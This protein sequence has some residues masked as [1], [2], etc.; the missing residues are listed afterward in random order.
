MEYFDSH[1]HCDSVDEF[2]ELMGRAHDAGVTRMLAVG[3]SPEADAVIMSIVRRFPEI[4]SGAIGF[5]RDEAGM[6]SSKEDGIAIAV[7]DLKSRIAGFVVE[8]LN[9]LAIGEVGLDFH[10]ERETSDAQVDLLRA[11][12]SLAGELGLPV[13]L[14]SREADDEMLKLLRTHAEGYG[15]RQMLGVLHCFTGGRKFAEALLDLGY[16][17]SFSGIVTFRNADALR[18]VV[19]IVPDECLL[20]ETDSPYLAP[21]PHRGKKNEPAYLP[22][23]AKV[24]ADLRGV[25]EQKIAALTA[26]NAERL[27]KVLPNIEL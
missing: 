14:H 8:G 16:Y 7:A 2:I 1:M 10:Y 3:G 11:Q 26:E 20:I 4:V 15:D 18:E 23:V 21:V 27:F 24:I 17:I 13:V 6:L 9:V 5:G 12:L 22:H 19:G 25:S